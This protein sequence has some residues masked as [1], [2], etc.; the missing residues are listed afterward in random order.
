MNT[1]HLVHFSGANLANLTL[2]TLLSFH[3]ATAGNFGN[4]A[5]A[6]M[7]KSQFL[8]LYCSCKTPTILC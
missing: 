6:D 3:T 1:V 4:L 2:L 7:L 5:G 8:R